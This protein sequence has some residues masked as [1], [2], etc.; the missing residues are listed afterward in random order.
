MAEKKSVPDL[1]VVREDGGVTERPAAMSPEPGRAAPVGA[2]PPRE[3]SPL[4]PAPGVGGRETNERPA[5][6]AAPPQGS[7][8][9]PSVP[10]PARESAPSVATAGPEAARPADVPRAAPQADAGPGPSHPTQ[11]E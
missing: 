4:S 1:S 8:V 7:A 6:A 10:S 3:P 2:Q 5:T 11:N 9:P